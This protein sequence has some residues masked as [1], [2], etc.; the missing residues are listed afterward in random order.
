M[1]VPCKKGKWEEPLMIYVGCLQSL[2]VH[3]SLQK[4]PNLFQ[5]NALL[6]HPQDSEETPLFI[7]SQ[8]G[9]CVPQSDA[10]RSK[11]FTHLLL[12]RGRQ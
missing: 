10:Q 6:H 4:L 5:H 1:A 9:V 12:K 3:T 8:K 2:K 7:A 11:Q